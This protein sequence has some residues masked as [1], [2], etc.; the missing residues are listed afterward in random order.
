MCGRFTLTVHH[1]SSSLERL[2]VNWAPEVLEGYRPRYNIAPS[3]RHWFLRSD[4][5]RRELVP[6]TWGLI[7][8]WSKD[9]SVAFKQINAR[10]ETLAERPAFREAFKKRRCVIPAD[11]FYEWHGPKGARDPV[12]FHGADGGLLWFAGLFEDWV[13]PQ[14]GEVKT[15][16]TIVT[17]AANELVSSVHNRMPA[18]IAEGD[19]DAWLEGEAPGALLR[20]A[21][22]DRLKARPVSRR[23]SSV[24]YDD[25][26]CLEPASSKQIKLF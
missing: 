13:R 11:G 14:T 21:P 2:G 20:P 26:A 12:W 3:N 6:A 17:T 22:V 10:A 9:P 15:T 7:N 24:K 1:I 25:P 8:H 4:A 5:A 18:L 16:F 23:V 19:F